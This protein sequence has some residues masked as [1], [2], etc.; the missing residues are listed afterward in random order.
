MFII[1]K[2]DQSKD[3]FDNLKTTRDI[4]KVAY[5]LMTS[6]TSDL[7]ISRFQEFLQLFTTDYIFTEKQNLSLLYPLITVFNISRDSITFRK[8]LKH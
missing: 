1:P 2:S 6:L 8:D 3:D 7:K 5:Q 4:M